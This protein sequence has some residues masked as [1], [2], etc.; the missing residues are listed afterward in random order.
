[1][2]EPATGTVKEGQPEAPDDG[3]NIAVLRLFGWTAAAL[4][5][6]MAILAGLAWVFRDHLIVMGKWFVGTLGGPGVAIGFFVPDAFMVP[7]PNDAFTLIG[8]LGGMP[9]W[10]V[11]AWGTVGSIA[12][13]CTGWA[14]GRYLIGRSKWLRE[15]MDKRGGGDAQ[16]RLNRY[17]LFFVFLAAITPLP[18]SVA[19]WAAGAARVPFPGFLAVSLTRVFRVAIYLWLIERGVF[20][21]AGLE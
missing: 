10:I 6:V 3:S 19:C 15:Y 12:G 13:G 5:A 16:K 7:L 2:Q 18:Y 1:M 4:A 21:V 8:R 11:V 20:T 14:I 9:F 17:G